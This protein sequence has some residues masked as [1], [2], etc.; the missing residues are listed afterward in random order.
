MTILD[1]DVISPTNCVRQPF[2]YSEVSSYKSIIANRLNL[3]W[4][5]DW[6]GIP[7]RLNDEMHIERADIVIGC[8]DSKASRRTVQEC[9]GKRSE[10]GYWLLY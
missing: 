8:V 9:A 7:K 4:G 5:L 1:A 10:V 6:E 3:F 2:S